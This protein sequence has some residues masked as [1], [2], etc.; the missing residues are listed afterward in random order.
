MKVKIIIPARYESSRFPGK[1]LAMIAGKTLIQRVYEKSVQAIPKENVYVATDSQNIYDHCIEHNMNVVMTSS[2]CLTGTDRIFE[3]SEKIKSDLYINV[4]GDEP[5][6]DPKDI[7]K[8]IEAGKQDPAFVHCGYCKI[9]DEEE[10]FSR[11]VPK[12]VFDRNNNL[13]YMSR[14]GIPHNKDGK[15]TSGH[16]QVC[17]YSFNKDHL[18]TFFSYGKKT[19]LE[20]VEDLELLR[21]LELG[22]SVKMVQVS[23]SSIAVDFPEDIKRVEEK[24]SKN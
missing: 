20:S 1:P 12:I 10:F 22:H 13:L 11:S 9:K 8:V 19:P 4:Q 6:I 7:L 21:F 2:A 23:Q 15:F 5:M 24:L 18:E 3:A 14:S 16:K 17:I